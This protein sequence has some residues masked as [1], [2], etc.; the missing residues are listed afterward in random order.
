MMTI[1]CCVSELSVDY[2][3]TIEPL[4][5]S[6]LVDPDHSFVPSQVHVSRHNRQRDLATII[7]G[8]FDDADDD[9]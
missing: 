5:V 1:Y 8:Q 9:D 6:S 7:D 4:P 2:A 3:Q